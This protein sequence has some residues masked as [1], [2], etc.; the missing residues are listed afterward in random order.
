M[1]PPLRMEMPS[2]RVKVTIAPSRPDEHRIK[3]LTAAVLLVEV[4][5][6]RGD[7]C[8]FSYLCWH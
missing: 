7:D 4:K 1:F 5:R 8:A 2:L 3:Y 6:R